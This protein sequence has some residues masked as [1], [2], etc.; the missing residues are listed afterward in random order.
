MTFSLCFTAAFRS[1]VLPIA[2][3]FQPDVILVSCGFDA[4]AG[5]PAPLGGYRVTP[6]CF[7]WMVQQLGTVGHGK[8]CIVLR[9]YW[10][11]KK[12]NI[13]QYLTTFFLAGGSSTGGRVGFSINIKICYPKILV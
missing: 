2:H 4:A 10:K 5:H 9:T 7:G 1:V 11:V 12:S 13:L 3:D 8:V 6:A